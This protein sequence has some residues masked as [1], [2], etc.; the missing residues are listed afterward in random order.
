[1]GK[2]GESIYREK[3]YRIWWWIGLI[4]LVSFFFY[5]LNLAKSAILPFII[6]IAIVY[7]LRSPVDWLEERK[8]PRFFSIL[9][10]YLL[11]I[12]LAALFFI[13]FVP[14]FIDQLVDFSKKLPLYFDTLKNFFTYWESRYVK[15]S[16]PPQ[17]D[18]ILKRALDSIEG[19]LLSLLIALPSISLSFVS[20]IFSFII[21]PVI[22]FY[23]LKDFDLIKETI[24]GLIPLSRREN[25]LS[26]LREIDEV[27]KGFI[28]GQFLVS[29]IVGILAAI[30]LSILKVD[31]AILI[32]LI[33]GVLNIIPYFG[34]I[35]GAV[36]AVLVALF[37]SPWTA[38]W[39]LI[40][41]IVIQQI[42]ALFLS[43]NI[44]SYK[45]RLHPALVIL[46]LFLGGVFWGILG[47]LVAIPIVAALKAVIYHYMKEEEKVAE[48]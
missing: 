41:L 46:A 2:E 43:P 27:V 11:G 12:I 37:R 31:F 24:K 45:V 47:M 17:V 35:A 22:A 26:L 40:A 39:A 36:L 25:T 20:S 6:A 21:A 29:L 14:L 5:L 38:L 3:V 9:L 44:I 8:I 15:L 19:S 32:G 1:M 16:L 34:P 33:T 48:Q 13:F 10:L 7:I 23:I 42:D 28:V 30:A 18:E 4:L